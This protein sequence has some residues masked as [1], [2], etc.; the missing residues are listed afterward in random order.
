MYTEWNDLS[1]IERKTENLSDRT[2]PLLDRIA[3]LGDLQH[4][5]EVTLARVRLID[6][7]D[8]LAGLGRRV[9][10]LSQLFRENFSDRE[11]TIAEEL[12]SADAD[13]FQ[14][15]VKGR[16]DIVAQ[17]TKINALVSQAVDEI[18][19]L[20]K[21]LLLL[22]RSSSAINSATRNPDRRDPCRSPGQ[23]IPPRL[24]EKSP[25]ALP[26]SPS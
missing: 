26:R 12:S 6:D 25:A 15:V 24:W 7:L 16:Q 19:A 18:L 10:N 4:G 3:D 1:R 23:S 20:E 22:R 13:V 11:D 5:L 2:I 17:N 21:N 9:D 14:N 8:G